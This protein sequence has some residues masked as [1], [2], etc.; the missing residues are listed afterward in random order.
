[1]VAECGP[2]LSGHH[3]LFKSHRNGDPHRRRLWTHHRWALVDPGRLYPKA[4]PRV[5]V[6]RTETL[7]PLDRGVP[8]RAPLVLAVGALSRGGCVFSCCL[9]HALANTLIGV[10]SLSSISLVIAAA[11]A[12]TGSRWPLSAAGSQSK[13][14]AAENRNGLLRELGEAALANGH[15]QASP[16]NRNAVPIQGARFFYMW[17]GVQEGA[18]EATLRTPP[19]LDRADGLRASSW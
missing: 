11:L 6:R 3:R 14:S 10:L 7:A 4:R 5:H 8:R 17:T 15:R 19:L 2:D 16:L 12:L 9:L 18:R 1:M 13:R